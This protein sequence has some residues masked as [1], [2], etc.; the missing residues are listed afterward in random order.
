MTKFV[1]HVEKCVGGVRVM[2][3]QESFNFGIMRGIT[4]AAFTPGRQ[5]EMKR[6]Y[7]KLLMFL[8]SSLPKVY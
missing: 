1:W 2:A 7:V 5:G 8:Y 6:R 3:Q 4:I